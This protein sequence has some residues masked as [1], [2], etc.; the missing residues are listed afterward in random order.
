MI[1]IRCVTCGKPLAQL[2]DKYLEEVRK[3]KLNKGKNVNKIEFLS[4]SKVEKTAEGHVMDDLG[5]HRMCC[6]RT[7]LGHWDV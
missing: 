3:H 2:Y 4:T 5:I 6:R 7:F 1:V